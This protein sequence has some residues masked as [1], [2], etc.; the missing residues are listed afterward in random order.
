MSF[1]VIAA[2][3]GQRDLSIFF[4]PGVYSASPL[5]LYMG[6]IQFGMYTFFCYELENLH[7]NELKAAQM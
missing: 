4:F 7:D 6:E 1:G 5:G 2:Q 3:C